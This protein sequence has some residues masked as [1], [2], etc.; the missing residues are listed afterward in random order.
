[1][2]NSVP[3]QDGVITVFPGS[4]YSQNGVPIRM[5]A[6]HVKNLNSWVIGNGPTYG[7]MASAVTVAAIT[8]YYIFVIMN[9]LNGN[10]EIMFDDNPSG[11]NVSSGTYTEKRRIGAFKTRLAGSYGSFTIL[12]MYSIGD[13]TFIHPTDYY[14]SGT[15]FN[16]SGGINNLYQTATLTLGSGL[17]LPALNLRADLNIISDQCDFGLISM[18]PIQFTIP[19]GL[20]V[21]GAYL[22]EYVFRR[23]GASYGTADLA[24]IVTSANQIKLAMNAP[25][26][27]GSV[28]IRARGFHDDRFI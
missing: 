2:D 15:I 24:I 20:V 14:N 12:E 6:N 11:T 21:T 17:A 7:G 26:G 28:D 10:T 3:S 25:G 8:W 13:H 22:G 23:Y 1:M 19:S 4:C 9:P 5:D 27:A 16:N 18:Y